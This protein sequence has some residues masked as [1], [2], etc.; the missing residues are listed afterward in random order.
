[1]SRCGHYTD[2][3]CADN[4][5]RAG[6]DLTS[7]K[8]SQEAAF[9]RIVRDAVR[10]GPFTKGERDVTLA[11]VNHWFHHKSNGTGIIHPGRGKL[12][13]KAGVTEKTVSRLL[14]RLREAG[15]ISAQGHLKGN[16]YKATEYEVDETA[17]LIFCGCTWAQKMTRNVPSKNAEMSHLQRDKM[18][19]RISNVGRH[20][21]HL[22]VVGGSH[23]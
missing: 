5:E 20:S 2:S 4:T 11:L 23:D 7:F 22:R 6:S 19:H 12:A 16:R 1:M 21:N 15:V 18:S 10:K 8:D 17:L 14:K 3:A 13:K 9:R